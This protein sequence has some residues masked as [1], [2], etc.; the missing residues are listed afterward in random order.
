MKA[1]IHVDTT[2]VIAPLDRRVYGQF[3][4]H[5]GRCI[6]GGIWVGEEAGI[7]NVRGYRL[8]VLDAVKGIRPPIMRWPG[9]NFVSQYH[10]EDGIGPKNNRPR[11][12]EMAW[13][14]EEPNEFGTDEFI[15]WT[16]IVGTEPYITVNAGN[17]TPEEAAHWVEYCNSTRNTNYA[18]LRRKYGHPEP[19]NVKIWGIGNELWGRFQVGFCKDGEECGWRTV[20]FANEMK[21]VDPSIQ[22]VAVGADYDPEWNIDVVRIAGNYIDYLS[23]HTYIFAD[24]QGKTYEELVAWPTAI[25]ENLQ[26]IYRIVEQTRAKYRIHRSIKLAFDEWNVWYPE[27]QPPHLTQVTSVK[28]AVFT[29]LVLNA[30]QRLTKIVPIACFAQTVNVLPLIVTDDEGRLILTP[31]YHVFRLYSEINGGDV[32]STSGF[33]PSYVSKELDTVVNYLDS[34]AVYSREESRLYLTVV[35]RH[36]EEEA[37]VNLRIKGF[38]PSKAVHKFVAGFSVEDRNTF[39]DPHK[40]VVEKRE[41]AVNSMQAIPLPPHSVNLLIL[42]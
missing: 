39:N 1:C 7:P 2:S 4:E 41:L 30:L 9:G 26:A 27:A 13:G 14:A 29:G 21:R 35:N 37:E 3:I 10:W 11:R 31:Q 36:P 23:I 18:S 20:E 15:E 16:R 38:P 40:V 6:Y 25:E 17:G 22:L 19:Y 12:F 34:S 42:E 5:L 8:D 33:S 28:D 24:R 32:V